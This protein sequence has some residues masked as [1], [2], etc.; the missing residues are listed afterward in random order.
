MVLGTEL[1]KVDGIIIWRKF[2]MY[3]TQ[4]LPFVEVLVKD[5]SNYEM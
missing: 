4:K 3:E 5:G 1:C 2:R